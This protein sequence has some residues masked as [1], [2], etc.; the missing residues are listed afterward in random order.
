MPDLLSVASRPSPAAY[1]ELGQLMLK[2]DDPQAATEAFSKGLTLSHT[3]S[4][5]VPRLAS[6]P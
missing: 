2:L 4:I 1:H 5:S 6:N 3:G